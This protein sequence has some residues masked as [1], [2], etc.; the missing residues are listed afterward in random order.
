M[1]LERAIHERWAT[2]YLLCALVPVDRLT[3]GVPRGDTSFPY[4]VLTR[5]EDQV[6]ARTSSGTSIASRMAMSKTSR[7][8]FRR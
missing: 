5:A 1:G 7:S 8:S 3:T 2:D 6:L 4:V